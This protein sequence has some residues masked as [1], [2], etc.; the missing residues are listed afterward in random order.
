[1][2]FKN[3]SKIK[4][5]RRDP[6]DVNKLVPSDS[7]IIR[8]PVELDENDIIT[9][10]NVEDTIL[11]GV[12][13]GCNKLYVR[14]HPSV[15]TQSECLGIIDEGTEVTIDMDSGTTNDFYKVTTRDGLNGYCM[16]KYINIK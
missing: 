2:G 13:T 6:I 5:Q 11:T 12:V 14:K 10:D 3:Y 1:M 15:T 9:I 7:S 16:K 8:E 4:K